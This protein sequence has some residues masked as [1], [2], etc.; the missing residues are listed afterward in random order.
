MGIGCCSCSKNSLEK[1]TIL[2]P[3]IHNPKTPEIPIEKKNFNKEK[4]NDNNSESTKKC[5]NENSNI[6]TSKK[7]ESLNRNLSR[8]YGGEDGIIDSRI[9]YGNKNNI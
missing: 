1:S 3:I 6:T 9:R 5:V 2:E 7:V 4:N 8:I